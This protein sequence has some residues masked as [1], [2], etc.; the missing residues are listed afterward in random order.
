MVCFFPLASFSSSARSALSTSFWLTND[1]ILPQRPAT[2]RRFVPGA[3]V[4]SSGSSNFGNFGNASSVVYG[5]GGSGDPTTF[6][7]V[8]GTRFSSPNFCL[9]DSLPP[10]SA[11]MVFQFNQSIPIA[12]MLAQTIQRRMM[13]FLKKR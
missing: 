13:I 2:N 9:T 6:D 10:G 4:M 12:R 3:Y 8:H 7:V 1:Q 11:V 5:G